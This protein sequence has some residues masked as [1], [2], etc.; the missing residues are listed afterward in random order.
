MHNNLIAAVI[1]DDVA[2]TVVN[3]R[4]T[5]NLAYHPDRV[6]TKVRVRAVGHNRRLGHAPGVLRET[7]QIIA[8]GLIMRTVLQATGLGFELAHYL[9][10]LLD[11]YTDNF[12]SGK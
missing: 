9:D 3:R 4:H 12:H 8:D 11:A 1:G 6:F 7:R 5:G 10:L 2:V